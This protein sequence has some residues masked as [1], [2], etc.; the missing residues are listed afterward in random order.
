MLKAAWIT[1]TSMCT[2]TGIHAKFETFVVDIICKRLHSTRK[3]SGVCDQIA[4]CIPL[5][6]TPAIVNDD[7]LVSGVQITLC[8][9]HIGNIPNQLL[10]DVPREGIP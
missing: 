4:I 10:I 2:N 3:F 7:V 8:N 6:Q 5:L 1:C 9:K